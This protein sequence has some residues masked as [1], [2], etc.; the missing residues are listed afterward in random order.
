MSGHQTATIEDTVYFWFGS[1]DTSG[2]GGDGATPLYD[3][4]E[5][6]AA[7]GAAPL[8]SGTP[9][10]LSHGDYPAGCYE[11]AVAATTGN[12]F[13]ADDTFAVFCTLAI[14]SQNPTGFVGSC[15]LTPLAKTAEL[16][17]VPK[18]DGTSTWNTTALA[19]IQTEANDALID[20]NLDH[21][22]KTATAAADMTTEVADNTIL[23]RLLSNGNT[24]DFV[25]STDG[26]QLIRDAITALNNVSTT[27]IQDNALAKVLDGTIT[28]EQALMAV[29]AFIGGLSDG[30][31]T[32]TITFKR[33]DD[34]TDCITLT[35]DNKGNRSAVVFD[36]A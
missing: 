24:S 33:Q 32:P 20:N 6:G 12:G 15:T 27:D 10:L 28:G 8:L 1:N 19:A 21:L 14:D 18:S 4:R 35:V 23:S 34:S 29:L 11:V 25:P 13:A 16:D 22:A 9:T 2:S 7:A 30:G 36:F 26:L 5:A 3:V 17:K 31:G